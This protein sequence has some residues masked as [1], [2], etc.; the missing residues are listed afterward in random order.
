MGMM[1]IRNRLAEEQT[2]LPNA[3]PRLR[4]CDVQPESASRGGGSKTK[5]G[6]SERK[7]LSSRAIKT[8][9]AA[10]VTRAKKC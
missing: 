7:R 2:H 8:I 5:A 1:T 9:H 3:A 4:R 10:L 6:I